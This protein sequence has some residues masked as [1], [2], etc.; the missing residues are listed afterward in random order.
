MRQ[1]RREA[2]A[3]GGVLAAAGTALGG[4]LF[5]GAVCLCSAATAK[6][7][8]A[9]LILL[10]LCAAFLFYGKLR[11][12]LSPPILA[13]G[14]VVLAGCVSS[15]YALSGKYALN[16]SLKLVSAFCLA[17]LLLAF[18]G[19]RRPERRAACVL[20]GC[21][22]LAGL[23]SIDLL[24]THWISGP[25]L[26][27]LGQFTPDY[28]QL[29]VVEE[30][31]RLLSVFDAPNPFAGFMG[32]GVLLSLGLAAGAE[33]PARRA[34]HLACLSVS[35]LAFVL[36]FSMGACGAIVPAFL[37]FLALTEPER[38]TGLLIVMAETLAVTVLAAFPIS[39]TS[40]TAWT[41]P[42]PI[43]LLCTV[44]GA[45]ALCALDLLAGRR[46]A[47]ALKGRGRAV[48]C[49]TAAVFAAAAVF[50]V[51]ACLLTT[52]A[53]VGPG[54]YLRRSAYPAPGRYTVTARE[55]GDPVVAIQSQSREDAMMHTYEELYQ[56]PLSQAEFTAPEG[57]L[58]VWFTFFG[59]EEAVRLESVEYA[60]EAG[61]GGVPLGYRLL[62][63]FIANRLQGLRANQNAIQRLVFFEDGLKLFA[64]S[65]LI[66]SGLGAFENGVRSVQ[67]FP[68]GTKYVHNHYI[69]TLAETGLV[70]LALFLGLLGAS[71]AA[72]WRGRGRPLAPALGAALLF[73]AGHG[74]VEVDFSY[75]AFLPMAFGA[76]A[77]IGL[78]CGD[79]AP[80]PGWLETK[81]V[82]NGLL[83]GICAL[84]ALYGVLL[85]RNMAAQDLAARSTSLEELEEAAS[86]DPF[87]WA[88]H[89]LTYVVRV[90]GREVDEETRRQ[91]D[92][93]A[94]R[95]GELSSNAVPIRLAE[96]YFETGRMELG[97]EMAE[98]YVGYVSADPGAWERTFELLARYE[99][100]EEAFRAG[101]ARIAGLLEEWNEEN[102]GHI[103]L[104]DG[105]QAFVDRMSG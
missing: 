71:A 3:A 37:V 42:R 16:E 27:L 21:C 102:M 68:Y 12:R 40:M 97:F 26:A 100:E 88:D 14:L 96:Y 78:S 18:T 52:G 65:P 59:G 74:A 22:A 44:G 19:G 38:R 51:A 28:T 50:A 66:G 39:V 30:G 70:G 67:A 34:A 8:G 13:L 45:A 93:Y 17:L 104:E 41:G 48:L 33:E 35:S 69:Q 31:V 81:A 32:V 36:A 55:E 11:D 92:E 1:G 5:F 6:S 23:V 49:L 56:G 54:E 61:S 24:S 64:R 89:M 103:A 4:L 2:G 77:V 80:R 98:Q 84:L 95:L 62:P 105:T 91:A 94:A 43:P 99:R 15:V 90:T 10:T 20:E 73:M 60:G 53:E 46:L 47:A 63:S 83:L 7:M 85:G 75:Y 79:R 58:V 25:V 76:F 57:S 82:K 87:E 29:G 101:V 86:M 9:L 72:V